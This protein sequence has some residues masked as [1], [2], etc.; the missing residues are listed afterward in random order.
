MTSTNSEGLSAGNKL[1]G[2]VNDV[3]KVESAD[4]MLILKS[5]LLFLY[6]INI[7]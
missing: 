4:F 2:K 1:N 7:T 6:E 5:A 3:V